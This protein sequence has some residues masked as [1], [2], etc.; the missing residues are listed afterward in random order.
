[1]IRLFTFVSIALVAVPLSAQES[2]NLAGGGPVAGIVQQGP[3]GP[4]GPLVVPPLAGGGPGGGINTQGGG[5]PGSE[6]YITDGASGQLSVVQGNAIVRSWAQRNSCLPIAVSS[7]VKTYGEFTSEFG[8]EYDYNGTWSGTDYP[9][10]GPN[11]QRVDGATD[12]AGRNWF[13]GFG[14]S[15]IYECDANWANPVLLFAVNGPT[16]VTYD[17]TTGNLWVISFSDQA[18]HEFQLDGTLVSSFPYTSSSSWLG[19]LG[20]EPATDTLWCNDFSLGNLRQYDKAGNL[21]QDVLIPGLTGYTWGGEFVIP[22]ACGPATWSNYGAGWP[23]TLG[24]P[25]IALDAPP[26]IGTTI[27]L[28]IDNSLGSFTNG[29]LIMGLSS[30]SI[31][32]PLGGTLLVF[33]NWLFP[34]PI[35]GGGLAAP[36][37]IPPDPSIC[38]IDLF[39]QA[40]ENDAG[41]SHGISF[42]PGLQMTI[43]S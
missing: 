38:G 36:G 11:G 31:G 43:G 29:F 4:A 16:G 1:M 34:I 39:L 27:T 35:P 2:T 9:D 26:V 21:L 3:I 7:T 28:L 6:M 14:D 24:I 17:A 22:K 41:A 18:I 37:A 25:G 32:T 12:G 20:W 10:A 5:G 33:P 13:A 15:A 23:G 40:V 30:A 19:C 42:T 8:S